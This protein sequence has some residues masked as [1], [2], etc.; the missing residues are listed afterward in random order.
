M[1]RK[2]AFI[3]LTGFTMLFFSACRK[4]DEIFNQQ[5][6][7]SI[8]TTAYLQLSVSGVQQTGS[9]LYALISID[10]KA[11]QAVVTNKKIT[12]DLIQG[13][14]KTDKIELPKGEFKL[15]KFIVVKASDTAVFASPLANSPKAA[16]VTHPLAIPLN[17]VK[18]GINTA[19]VQVLN[20]AS[21]DLPAGFGYTGADFGFQTF[22]N[23]KVKLKISVGQVVYDS[24]PGKLLI[25]AVNQAG[26]HWTREIDMQ[27]GITD[28][29][30]PDA[31]S[32]YTFKVSK[33]MVLAQKVLGAGELHS[34]MVVALETGR[35]PKR[36][37]EEATFIE[38]ALALVPDSRT[39][40]FYIANL[41]SGIKYY[42]KSTQVS[43]LPLT[44]IYKFIYSG[45]ELDS[46]Q[47]FGP[48]N[49]STGYTT[50]DYSGG[51]ISN[52]R[53]RSYDQE[54]GVAIEYTMAGN[55][56]VV[57]IDYLFHNGHTMN[58]KFNTKDGNRISEQALSST[59]GSEGGT[60]EYD[61]YINPKHQL[62]YPDI[63]F[64]NYSKNNLTRE[65]KNYAGAIPSVVPYKFE[66]V[67]D[68]DGYPSEVYTSY[69]GYSSQ[70]HLYRIKKTYKYQ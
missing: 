63:F 48:G 64:L 8:D 3:L 22:T 66:Y 27:K 33:W 20:I 10:S 13:S 56:E 18:K 21:S 62:G 14:Y 38:N 69:K 59:G 68:N 39:E 2:I 44:N 42:L 47:R 37:V 12:L 23:L 17:I 40:Y 6:P 60:F 25:D 16:Q 31:Y 7:S 5:P 41:L 43:G 28:I 49:I 67:Y 34:N 26:E 58:Y 11:G 65:Q 36:L 57:E 32:S 35:Q 55:N 45:N 70:Q 52:M 15:S 46:I 30:V 50:F 19:V 24:L 9:Q 29:R 54:T 61:S 53:N 4:T 1:K 51:K